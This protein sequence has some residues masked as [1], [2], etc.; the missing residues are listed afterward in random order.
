MA[1]IIGH[2]EECIVVP[3]EPG[4][5]RESERRCGGVRSLISL[6]GCHANKPLLAPNMGI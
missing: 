5:G 1:D 2:G 4:G 3:Q 6:I